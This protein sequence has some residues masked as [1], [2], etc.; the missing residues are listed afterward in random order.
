MVADT[1]RAD[2]AITPER[3]Y[4]RFATDSSLEDGELR[5]IEHYDEIA[6]Q[7]IDAAI[8][9]DGECTLSSDLR[10]QLFV[11]NRIA[12]EKPT[13]QSLERLINIISDLFPEFEFLQS[14][15]KRS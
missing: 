6:A 2:I 13:E 10:M 7:I 8:P 1:A 3:T 11:N 15:K 12:P 9:K 5:A 14:F 4:Y